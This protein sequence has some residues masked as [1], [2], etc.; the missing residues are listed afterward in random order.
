MTGSGT[1]KSGCPATSEDRR[2]PESPG[3]S[4]HNRRSWIALRAPVLP[5]VHILRTQV[6]PALEPVQFSWTSHR[7]MFWRLLFSVPTASP[8][9][10]HPE[11]EHSDSIIREVNRMT[12]MPAFRGVIQD[13]G[14]PDSEYVLPFLQTVGNQWCLCGIN[15]AARPVKT[16]VPVIKNNAGCLPGF[17]DI[18]VIRTK[19]IFPR[20]SGIRYDLASCRRF[21][22]LE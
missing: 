10:Y 8:R 18:R 5:A 1:G 3:A 4:S 14:G 17:G 19:N 20:F 7:S 16:S 22:Y 6:I 15:A 12:K 21:G 13:V 9:P 2:N 11:P